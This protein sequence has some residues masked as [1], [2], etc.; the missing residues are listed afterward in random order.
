M[1]RTGASNLPMKGPMSA[2]MADWGGATPSWRLGRDSVAKL[3]S[4]FI[5]PR[6]LEMELN[7]SEGSVPSPSR[8]EAKRSRPTQDQLSFTQ[9]INPPSPPTRVV[10]E[11]L[12][13]LLSA[14]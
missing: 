1:Q 5:A 10:V 13:L 6:R 12:T 4:S 7:D 3:L 14:L 2:E 8:P 11:G 9:S